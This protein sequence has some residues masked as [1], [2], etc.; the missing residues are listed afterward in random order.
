MR[1]IDNYIEVVGLD[2]EV[3]SG[4]GQNGLRIN[5]V[6]NG[7][8]MAKAIVDTYLSFERAPTAS[9]LPPAASFDPPRR[10]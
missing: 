4:I 7:G 3:T 1:Q 9:L 10:R 5:T 2:Y 8:T 6:P